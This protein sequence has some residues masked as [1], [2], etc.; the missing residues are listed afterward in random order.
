MKSSI[1]SIVTKHK[2]GNLISF[3]TVN[4]GI[5]NENYVFETTKG[6]FFFKNCRLK[7]KER[8]QYINDVERFME[9]KNI[10]VLSAIIIDE[11][12]GYMLYPF[13][14]SDRTH[15]YNLKDYFKMGE[16]LA[17]IHAVTYKKEIAENLKHFLYIERDVVDKLEKLKEY[18]ETLKNKENKDKT[19]ILFLEYIEKK[20]LYAQNHIELDIL[21][22]DTLIHGDFHAGN[23]LIDKITR[24]IV[25][26]CDWEKAQ[27]APRALEIAKAYLFIAFNESAK[28]IDECVQIGDTLLEGYRSILFLSDEEF[29]IGLKL[30]IKSNIFTHWIEDR[31]Y[32]SKDDRANKF[33]ENG[34]MILDHFCLR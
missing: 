10:P 7:I 6:K 20:L 8:M 34:I 23:L 25:G 5:L 1:E 19:D 29:E 9:A 18:Q 16:I 12:E 33:I 22:N 14:E 11:E 2:L 15:N 26:V 32:L 30:R 31:Y 24:E 21:P 27:Y 17:K 3:N 4:E 28:S 13:I